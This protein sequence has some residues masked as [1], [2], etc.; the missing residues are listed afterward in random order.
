MLRSILMT[1][2]INDQRTPVLW[3]SVQAST[4]TSIGPTSD[5]T[6]IDLRLILGHGHDLLDG[7]EVKVV[8]DGFEV[9][10][11][12]IPPTCIVERLCPCMVF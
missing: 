10:T 6:T 7:V 11:R 9:E 4:S 1:T 2:V 5:S 12:R 3:A 8:L